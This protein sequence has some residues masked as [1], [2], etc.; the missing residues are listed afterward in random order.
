V[1]KELPSREQ[2]IAILRLYGCSLNVIEHSKAVAELALETARKLENKGFKVD[3]K[4]IEIGALL[5]DIGRSKQHTVD[6]AITGAK[7]LESMNL[8]ETLI[9]IIKRHVGGGI[10][11]EE[12]EE[13]GWPTGVYIPKSLEE[14]IV[15]LSDKLVDSSHRVPI[16]LAIDQLLN[17]N[18]KDAAER[19]RKLNEEINR[20]MEQ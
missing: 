1:S 20:L 8:P 17:D 4:L 9:L 14:K 7:I 11:T 12:A 3:S 10:T 13:L 6:H 16:K 19:V 18:K 15:S 5:H 2:A